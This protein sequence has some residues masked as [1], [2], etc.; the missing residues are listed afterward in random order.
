METMKKRLLLFLLILGLTTSLYANPTKENHAF[1]F[2]VID[3]PTTS[4]DIHLQAEIDRIRP[5]QLAFVV[6]NGIS[7]ISFF[8]IS[9]VY[10][11]SKM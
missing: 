10:F 2:A 8:L 3:Q 9:E 11:T 4:N 5:Q 1:Y 7:H 6:T